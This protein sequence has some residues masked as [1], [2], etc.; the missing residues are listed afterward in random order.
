MAKLKPISHKD[1]IQRLRLFGFKG[2]YSGGKHLYMIKGEF[3]LTV[4][5]P[6]AKEI[7]VDLLKRLLSQADIPR[8][9]WIEVD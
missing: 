3:R 9:E 6:H 4:P 5:N 8:E 7:S 1:F 2:P